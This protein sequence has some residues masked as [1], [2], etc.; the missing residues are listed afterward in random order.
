MVQ[1]K[2][3]D[4]G[5]S[6]MDVVRFPSVIKTPA[7]VKPVKVITSWKHP[8]ADAMKFNVDDSSKGKPRPAGIGG[9]LRDSS[10]IVKI[11]FSKSI[12]VADSN[13]AELL[14]I[15]EAMG[16]FVLS[17]W[18]HSHKLIIENNSSNVVRWMLNP[19][20]TPWKLKIF[21]SHIE[22]MKL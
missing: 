20:S 4:G 14:A 18:F 2:W 7:I 6:L 8:P 10:T 5:E 12:G 13:V 16:I 19:N 11:I 15:R 3:P 9:V 1:T 22:A 17:K 21:M